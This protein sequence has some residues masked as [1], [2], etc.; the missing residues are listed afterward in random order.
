MKIPGRTPIAMVM[1]ALAV[2]GAG[3]MSRR[4][5]AAVD[6]VMIVVLENADFSEAMGHPFLSRL[7][8]EGALLSNFHALAHPSQPNYVALTAGTLKGVDS[9]HPVTLSLRHIGDLIEAKGLS[10]KA[11]AEDFPGD[12]YLKPESGDYARKHLPF[13]SFQNIQSDSLRCRQRVVNAAELAGDIANGRLPN[14]SLYVPNQK[15]DGHDTN[16]A[17]ADR[18]LAHTFGPLLRDPRFT[19][20][21]LLVVTFDES[22]GD[23]T[24]H[25][26]TSLWGESVLPGSTSDAHYDHYSLLRTVED[27]LGL[28]R[29]G[30][31]DATAA[32]IVGVWKAT[33]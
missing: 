27:V 12:C 9:N 32:P 5:S 23:G 30:Q 22:K 26:Y 7:A 4:N 14:Y 15:N 17:Y 1:L 16:V 10:W 11:Y 6:K 13:L 2:A 18:W 29:L 8:R 28:G 21:L 33:R 24:N 31:N 19:T 3:P 25:I 20:R